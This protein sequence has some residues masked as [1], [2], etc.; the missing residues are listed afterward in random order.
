MDEQRT[1]PGLRRTPTQARSRARVQ[2]ILAAAA[3]LL[4][5][6]GPEA[7]RPTDVA[8]RAEVPVGSVYQYFD[9]RHALLFV[10]VDQYLEEVRTLVSAQ[11]EGVDSLPDLVQRLEHAARD[12]YRLHKEQP[13]WVPL[14]MAIHAD[15]GLQER[16]LEDTHHLA[17]LLTQVVRGFRPELPEA[18][19]F[20]DLQLVMHL[21]IASLQLAL[22]ADEWT[23]RD[24][25]F[26]AWITMARHQVERS[27]FAPS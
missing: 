3:E 1:R 8:I 11:I 6:G 2:R 5:G 17:R 10:L 23:E 4:A 22:S 12:W 21:F 26:E 18:A 13:S 25:L 14:V 7:M 15:R 9:D 16:N 19:L 20:R 24:A 27:V